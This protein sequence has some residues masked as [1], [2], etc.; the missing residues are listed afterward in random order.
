VTAGCENTGQRIEYNPYE[1]KPA[2]R[3]NIENRETEQTQLCLALPGLAITHPDR[4]HLDLLNVILGEGMSSR[5]FTEIRDN[6]GLAY[7]IHSYAEHFLDTGAVTI[8]A[9]VDT[10]K[11]KFTISAILEELV[12]LREPVPE[13]ELNKAK[14]L[15]KGRILLRLEDSRSVAGWIGGQEILTGDILSVDRV[16]AE[17]ESITAEELMRVAEELLAEGELRAAVVGPVS[18]DEPIEDLLKLSR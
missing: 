1:A 2:R 14:E 6:L 11:L 3:V 16:I 7:S 5:L 12:R 15:Y 17:I 4:F 9:G 13:S 18:P 8:A 10:D